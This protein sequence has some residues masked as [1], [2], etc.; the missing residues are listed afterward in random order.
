MQ[1]SP[2]TSAY[3]GTVFVSVE[4]PRNAKTAA[5]DPEVLSLLALLVQKCK[6]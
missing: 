5:D 6:Y 4:H 3:G 1:Y 2:H